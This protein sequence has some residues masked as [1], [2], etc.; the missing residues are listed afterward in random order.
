LNSCDRR[1]LVYATSWRNNYSPSTLSPLSCWVRRSFTVQPAVKNDLSDQVGLLAAGI[2]SKPRATCPSFVH[3]CDLLFHL[4]QDACGRSSVYSSDF[5]SDVG[6]R[7]ITAVSI[8]VQLSIYELLWW[9]GTFLL[10]NRTVNHECQIKAA[11][12]VLSFL[13]M[14]KWKQNMNDLMKQW[15][16][17]DNLLPVYTTL[18]FFFFFFSNN[19]HIL[20]RVMSCTFYIIFFQICTTLYISPNSHHTFFPNPRH[21]SF[22][23][24][25]FLMKSS[26]M[27]IWEKGVVCGSHTTTVLRK[28]STC[29][30]QQE[31]RLYA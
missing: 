11:T 31:F 12:A 22:S 26:V 20:L 9:L 14:W 29:A 6:Y 5:S 18:L 8:T 2:P 21:T 28:S 30:Y 1:T 23:H 16:R 25:T 13:R 24:H 27:W 10:A 3:F 7:S 4:F 19:A 17:S 15:P